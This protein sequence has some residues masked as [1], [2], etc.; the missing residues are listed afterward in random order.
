[1]TSPILS[2][3]AIRSAALGRASA[4]PVQRAYRTVKPLTSIQ[5][6]E[7]GKGRFVFLAENVVLCVLG[8]SSLTGCVEV[9]CEEQSYHV[10]N[11]DLLSRSTLIVEPIRSMK[12][13]M[14]VCA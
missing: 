13:A 2:S 14:A 5:F 12:R 9:A 6:D 4:L 11:T 1:M 8:A 3:K 10:F 7:A